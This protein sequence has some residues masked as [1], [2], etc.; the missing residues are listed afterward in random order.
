M[1]SGIIERLGRVSACETA[2]ARGQSLRVTIET[3]YADLEL[4]ESV[5]VNGVCLTVAERVDP[6]V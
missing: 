3:G 1:F 6:A 5:A 4:G 2:D